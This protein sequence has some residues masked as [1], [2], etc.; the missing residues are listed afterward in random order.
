MACRDASAYPTPIIAM[1]SISIWLV[2]KPEL[3]EARSNF[4]E[5]VPIAPR[6]QLKGRWHHNHFY[7][8]RRVLKALGFWIA[9]LSR[10]QASRSN[11]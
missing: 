3:P 8:D 11:G 1:S 2:N 10:R 4:I 5:V 6:S 9:K 7:E